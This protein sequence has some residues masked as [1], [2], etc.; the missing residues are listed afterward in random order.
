MHLE[1]KGWRRWTETKTVDDSNHGA[2]LGP[3]VCNAAQVALPAQE[4][5]PAP[6]GSPTNWSSVPTS[7]CLRFGLGML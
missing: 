5:Y 3:P 1:A 7:L 6:A 2:V 4:R